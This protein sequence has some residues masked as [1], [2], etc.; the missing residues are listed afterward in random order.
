MPSTRGILQV[1]PVLVVVL[2]VSS[3]ESIALWTT[4]T[5][6]A[7]HPYNLLGIFGLAFAA[8]ITGS[9]AYRSAVLSD[10]LVF[11]AMTFV[12]VLMAV[13]MAHLTYA[14]MIAVRAMEAAMWTI[15][16]LVTLAVLLLG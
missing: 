13:R 5:I 12:S 1:P 15:A 16:L 4:I 9:I 2:A 3:Y 7:R 10:R 11:G 8:F 6:Y 14:A